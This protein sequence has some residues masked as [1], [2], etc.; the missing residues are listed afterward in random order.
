MAVSFALMNVLIKGTASSIQAA[1]KNLEN[2]SKRSYEL[3]EFTYDPNDNTIVKAGIVFPERE[4]YVTPG[5]IPF[6]SMTEIKFIGLG[7][8]G[9]M[10]ESNGSYVFYKDFGEKK[11][12]ECYRFS[13]VNPHMEEFDAQR[14]VVENVLN[15]F[16]DHVWQYRFMDYSCGEYCRWTFNGK[17]AKALIEKWENDEKGKY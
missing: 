7:D 6:V 10:Y 9:N 8:G 2:Y 16:M 1:L 5:E 3:K 11:I 13:I 15:S 4:E 14:D 17:K 12:S